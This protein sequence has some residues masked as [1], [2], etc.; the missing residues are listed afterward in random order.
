MAALQEAVMPHDRRLDTPDQKIDKGLN[1]ALQNLAALT[2][3]FDSPSPPRRSFG[4]RR[5][6]SEA[7]CY[8][9]GSKGHYAR[10]CKGASFSALPVQ[11]QEEVKW[12]LQH[13]PIGEPAMAVVWKRHAPNDSSQGLD[14]ALGNLHEWSR[15]GPKSK[16]L[17]CYMRFGWL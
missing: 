14:E 17:G 4:P 9:C 1:A 16:R 3:K 10:D 5:S 6:L 15:G 12:A 8:A 13:A 7:T 11:K 2:T